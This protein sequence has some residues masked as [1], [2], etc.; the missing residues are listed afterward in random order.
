M[1]SQFKRK[2]WAGLVSFILLALIIAGCGSSSNSGGSSGG[3]SNSGSSGGSSSSGS[4]ELVVVSFGGSYQDAQREAMFKPFEAETGI[5]VIEDSPT[6]AGKLK[7]MVLNNNVEWDVID[8]VGPDIP[9]LISEGLLEPIDYSVVD[10]TDLLPEAVQEYSVTI[11]FYTDVLSYHEESFPDGNYP[12]SWA[13]FFDLEKY[14]GS[15]SLQKTPIRTL[16]FALLAD[17]VDKDNLYPLD[18]DRAFKKLDTIKDHI[19]W[20]EERAQ[21]LQ[22]LSD[23]EVVMAAAPNGRVAA[24][25]A[26]GVPLRFTF[27]QGALDYEAWVV[28]KGS[29]NKENAMKFINYASQAKPQAD[30][31]TVMPY[32]PANTKAF[33]YMTE[34]F[35]KSLPTHEENLPLQFLIDSQWWF[36]NYDEVNDRFQQWLLE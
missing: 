11:D 19:I 21:V 35:A 1:R 17:G 20:W 26:E 30:L 3:G 13:D 8:F 9:I 5:K 22:M 29:K 15:R 7:S 12:Q 32:G 14:P 34:D 24:M 2:A 4:G 25:A 16:E 28:A 18:V 27:N 31:L 36:E 6:D 33:D 23:R 10:T